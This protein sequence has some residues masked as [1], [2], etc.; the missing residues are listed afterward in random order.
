MH[1]PQA[2]SCVHTLGGPTAAFPQQC[3]CISAGPLV[4]LTHP[5][6]YHP[7]EPTAMLPFRA[8]TVHGPSHMFT[9]S[10][11]PPLNYHTSLHAAPQAHSYASPPHPPTP[12]ISAGLQPCFHLGHS[13][14][15]GPLVCSYSWWARCCIPTVVCIPLCGPAH[16]FNSPTPTIPA[17]PQPCFHMGHSP[18]TG[19]LECSH[20]R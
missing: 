11:G 5:H 2:H 12:T 15:A 20:S 17:G 16:A 6:H 7:S 9:L 1:L 3:A 13:P 18:S 8:F 14:S 4:Q 19:P 10:V